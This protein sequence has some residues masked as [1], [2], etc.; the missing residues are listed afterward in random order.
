MF[1]S[2][3]NATAALRLAGGSS[4]ADGFES[5][6]RHFRRILAS[7][8]LEDVGAQLHRLVKR[9]ERDGIPLDYVALLEDLIRFGQ[10]PERVKT[11]WSLDFWQA[12]NSET[13]DT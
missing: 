7:R 6:E 10:R 13:A 12:A 8:D 3:V 4:K 5:M 2:D 1:C 9:L 11:R